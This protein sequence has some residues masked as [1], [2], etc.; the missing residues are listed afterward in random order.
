MPAN[1]TFTCDKCGRR[2][3]MP[4]YMRT[5]GPQRCGKLC[6]GFLLWDG[7]W[8]AFR[9][10]VDHIANDQRWRGQM[11]LHAITRRSRLAG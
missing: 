1:R 7:Y 9:Y 4:T 6:D 8:R 10:H 11:L 3:R 5:F 2:K